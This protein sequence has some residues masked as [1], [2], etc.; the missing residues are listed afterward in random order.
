MGDG[1]SR[2]KKL[3]KT[4]RRSL[5]ALHIS[6]YTRTHKRD[7]TRAR[8]IND[9][10][11]RLDWRDTLALLNSSLE[12]FYFQSPS[13]KG[14][15]WYSFLCPLSILCVNYYRTFFLFS[16][17]SR[18]SSHFQKR[19]NL[20]V[21]NYFYDIITRGW[22]NKLSNPAHLYFLSPSFPPLPPPRTPQMT[23]IAACAKL[24]NFFQTLSPRAR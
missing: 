6:I 21:L 18:T 20:L 15:R 2:T 19:S 16:F 4:R 17:L 9:A 5:Y 24:Y 10:V 14:E 8:W 7:C 13:G 23:D 1:L 22:C 3:W 12:K 11:E